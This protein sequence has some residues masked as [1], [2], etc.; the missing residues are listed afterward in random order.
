MKL[1]CNGCGNEEKHSPSGID[2]QG[3][4]DRCNIKDNYV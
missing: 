4:C 2:E 3:Y 1:Y